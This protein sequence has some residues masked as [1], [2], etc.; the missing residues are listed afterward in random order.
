MDA[1]APTAAYLVCHHAATFTPD[2]FAGW[3][4]TPFTWREQPLPTS[5][6]KHADDQTVA[7]LGV[8]IAAA[9]AAGLEEHDF[10]QW[11][12]IGAPRFIGRAGLDPHIRKFLTEGP[13]GATPHAIP[14]RCLHSPSGF[15]SQMLGWHGLNIGAGGGLAGAGDGLLAALAAMTP[16]QAGVWLVLTAFDPERLPDTVAASAP[17]W[18][19]HALA[20]ALTPTRSAALPHLGRFEVLPAAAVTDQASPFGSIEEPLLLSELAA[21]LADP[22]QPVRCWSMGHGCVVRWSP[23][24]RSDSR[25][26]LPHETQARPGRA[27]RGKE[28]H[29]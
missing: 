28:A 14:H 23:A 10:S 5:Q 25:H 20:L 24:A 29:A 7:S 8:V 11:G 9:R 2:E 12:V 13:W 22:A 1:L 17:P 27:A 6:F 18:K 16:D 3:R 19:L 26:D 4:K 21:L 15:I